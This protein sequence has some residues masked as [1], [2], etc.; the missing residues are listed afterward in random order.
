MAKISAEFQILFHPDMKMS[1]KEVALVYTFDGKSY[2]DYFA[3]KLTDKNWNVS[4]YDLAEG[5][6]M[7]FFVRCVFKDGRLLLGRKEGKNYQIQL[8][9]NT[10]QG[11]YKAQV[12]LDDSNL[13][14]AG[15]R[16]LIC[17]QIIPKDQNMCKTEQCHAV[18]CPQCN[19]MLPPYSN[20]CP[21]DK[22]SF[23]I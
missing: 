3:N 15:R 5:Q 10:E 18:F 19:R 20:F 14:Y 1:P 16:C 17:D 21:W 9:A 12:R 22:I 8:R 2:D 13:V 6:K 23:N 11:N 4:L 7:E